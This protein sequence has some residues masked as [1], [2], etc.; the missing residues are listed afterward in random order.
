MPLPKPRR[1]ALDLLLVLAGVTVALGLAEVGLRA[2]WP[3]RSSVTLGMFEP[4]EHAGYRLRAGYVNEI[5]V[6]EYRV[7]VHTDA[8]GYRV[9]AQDVPS[10]EPSASRLLAIGDSFTFGV[11]VDA[12]DAFPGVL[13][14]ELTEEWGHAWIVRN[15]GVGGYG[16]LRSAQRLLNVQTEWKPDVVVHALYLGN[17]LEDPR[18]DTFLRAPVVEKGRMVTPGYHPLLRLRLALRTG[19]HL[20]AFVRQ[21]VHGLYVA[22]VFA[23][24]SQYLGPMGLARWPNRVETVSWPAGLDA[25]R[26]IQD[27]AEGRDV[28][29]LVVLVPTRWQVEDDSWERYR[30]GWGQEEE[31]DRDHARRV[32]WDAL[33]AEGVETLDLLPVLR[34][35]LEGGEH[36][37][38]PHDTHWNVH[39]HSLAARE[40]RKRLAE[41][42]WL[43][44]PGDP[45]RTL[46]RAPGD[47]R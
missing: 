24:K 41:L 34:Q 30:R 31:F 27:W 35:D 45:R 20:Y 23:R 28:Q 18:P 16:P 39:G 13:E 1:R 6:P 29:Y 42:S 5:R 36:A 43:G 40:I 37:Y 10:V 21:H 17:D 19:S 8:D 11:G 22:S 15:G 3:Q 12:E 46:V 32:V 2:F 25:I 47:G 26:D 4:D 44:P 38:Y 7:Q 9:S 14:R 33:Q